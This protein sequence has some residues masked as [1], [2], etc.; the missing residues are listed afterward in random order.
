[1]IF[2]W[3]E[4]K[5]HSNLIKHWVRFE[6]ASKIWKDPFAIEILDEEN[7][8][9]EQRY[10]RIGHNSIHGI[11][12]VVFCERKDGNVIRIISARRATRTERGLYER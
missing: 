11:L 1:M 3:D 8:S 12:T 7:S 4:E 2:E 5:Y 9:P 10:L 6:N